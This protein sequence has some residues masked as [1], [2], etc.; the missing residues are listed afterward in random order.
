MS[1]SKL[2]GP[3]LP[4][5]IPQ[6]IDTRVKHLFKLLQ[7]LPALL[8]TDLPDDQSTYH[9]YL[10]AGDV[11]DEGI[12]FAFNRRLEIA[13]ATDNLRGGKSLFKERGQG[14]AKLQDFMRQ[15]IKEN[16]FPEACGHQK[17]WIERLI[18][19]AEDSG[20]KIP[21]K[22]RTKDSDDDTVQLAASKTTDSRPKKLHKKSKTIDLSQD[23][24]E[25]AT[26]AAAHTEPPAT[27][28][29]PS[30]LTSSPL[31][32]SAAQSPLQLQQRT[33]FQLGARKLT[34]AKAETQRKRHAVEAKEKRLE[35]AVRE[36]RQKALAEE[37]R[38][39]LA[40][41]RQQKF[42]D[43]KKAAKGGSS[44]RP[45]AL[46]LGAERPRTVA[47]DLN[48]AELSWPD[49]R[50]WKRQCT[51]KKNGVIQKRHQLL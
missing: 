37:Q 41:E 12:L 20:A 6:E 17:R 4:Q 13:F 51:G 50:K 43:L 14:I 7:H 35:A 22:R 5:G 11:A 23:S 46:F 32:P 2:V 8:P 16:P 30:T 36:K 44:Q 24:D 18:T 40:R 33:L 19:V 9:F 25:D 39:D 45:K 34:A 42:C 21:S 3:K 26:C 29:P 28:P 48:V 47:D 31:A 38:R 27:I 1:S 10:D 15:I 49:G